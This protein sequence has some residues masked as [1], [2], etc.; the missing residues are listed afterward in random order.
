MKVLV[1][2]ATGYLGGHVV[3]ALADAGHDVVALVRDPARLGSAAARCAQVRVAEATKPETLSGVAA[4]CDA[5]YS[6]VGIRSADRRADF[7]AVDHRANLNVFAEARRE[8]VER[9]VFVSVHRADE[10]RRAGVAVAEARERV[11]DTVA[12]TFPRWTVFRPTAYF[13]DMEALFGAIRR[14]GVAVVPDR[15]A[16]RVNPIHGAD[17]AARIAQSFDADADAD[18]G[19][20]V[21]VGGPDVYS[22]RDIVTLAFE[23]LGRRPR[24]VPVP[25]AL[26]TPARHLAS[27]F[28]PTL[29]AFLHA[30]RE[31][32][33]RADMTAPAFGARRLADRFA[34]LAAG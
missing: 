11:A 20:C 26:L 24:V 21:A 14:F 6:A 31:I 7:W 27:P 2:G 23:A 34:E 12:A 19:R 29:A 28:N 3:R 1:S 13:N 4:G 25:S 30:L 10:L 15:G 32:A 8:G 17:L 16:L 33:R 5:V 9:A 22:V 18:A